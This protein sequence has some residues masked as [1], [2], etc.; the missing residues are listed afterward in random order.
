M[1]GGGDVEPGIEPADF[2]ERCSDR[3]GDEHRGGGERFGEEGLRAVLAE[4]EQ[5][6]RGGD[7]GGKIRVNDSGEHGLEWRAERPPLQRGGDSRGKGPSVLGGAADELLRE[8]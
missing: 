6:H 1:A 5:F 3:G 2:V 8:R 4:P 7:E